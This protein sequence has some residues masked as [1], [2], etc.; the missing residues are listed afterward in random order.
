M[1][2]FTDRFEIYTGCEM[3]VSLILFFGDGLVSKRSKEK[4]QEIDAMFGKIESG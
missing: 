3:L 2:Q 4:E 1:I